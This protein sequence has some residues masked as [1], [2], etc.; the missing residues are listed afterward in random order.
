MSTTLQQGTTGLGKSRT[1]T[2]PLGNQ[3]GQRGDPRGI[4][5]PS[6]EKGSDPGHREAGGPAALRQPRRHRR[7]PCHAHGP[8]RNPAPRALQQPDRGVLLCVSAQLCLPPRGGN[9][10]SGR[11][12]RG[13]SAAFTPAPQPREGGGGGW[14]GWRGDLGH[15]SPLTAPPRADGAQSSSATRKPR[16]KAPRPTATQMKTQSGCPQPWMFL[17]MQSV[18]GSIDTMITIPPANCLRYG[19]PE[20]RPKIRSPRCNKPRVQPQHQ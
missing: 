20:K 4:P 15:R 12:A 3:T 14:P 17:E 6:Q 8:A 19:C 5:R 7:Q 9:A 16:P 10:A 13:W 2:K 1:G 11:A 18:T